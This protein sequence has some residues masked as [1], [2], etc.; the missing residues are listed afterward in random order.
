MET[1]LFMLLKYDLLLKEET[2]AITPERAI[3]QRMALKFAVTDSVVTAPQIV[4]Q[5]L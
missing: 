4:L 5:D 1:Y 2:R 3:L